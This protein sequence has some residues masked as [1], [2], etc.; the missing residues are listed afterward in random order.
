MDYF[1]AT[2]TPAVFSIEL[3]AV[4]SMVCKTLSNILMASGICCL[5]AEIENFVL[6]QNSVSV[7]LFWRNCT[8]HFFKYQ[9][10]MFILS[11]L[12]NYLVSFPWAKLLACTL[13]APGLF[14][15]GTRR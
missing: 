8:L 3:V 14:C 1:D 7:A 9:I 12:L 13:I 6:S 2:S 5:T 10:D 4:I 15:D 11:F